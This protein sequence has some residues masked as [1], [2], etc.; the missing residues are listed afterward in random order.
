MTEIDCKQCKCYR[1][2]KLADGTTED[3]CYP[4]IRENL[5]SIPCSRRKGTEECKF[6]RGE[7]PNL[8]QISPNNALFY[9]NFED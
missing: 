6:L 9:L 1:K 5:F 4:S 3:Y 2:D 7:V 8:T